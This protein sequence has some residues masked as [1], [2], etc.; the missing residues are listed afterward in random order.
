MTESN[1]DAIATQ[2]S[3]ESALAQ[4]EADLASS[5]PAKQLRLIREIEDLGG[6]FNFAEFPHLPKSRRTPFPPL[7]T[8]PVTKPFGN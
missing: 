8:G 3:R 5:S 2:P 7:W 1:N 6:L 4:L